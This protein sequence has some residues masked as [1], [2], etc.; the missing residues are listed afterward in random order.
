MD[1]QT[2][3]A[4]DL[5]PESQCNAGRIYSGIP[6]DE[7]VISAIEKDNLK[8]KCKQITIQQNEV[9]KVA[10]EERLANW[11][12]VQELAVVIKVSKEN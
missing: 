4:L 1:P 6:T 3:Y 2:G 9:M 12:L 7:C 8:N 5:T 10:Q 11:G